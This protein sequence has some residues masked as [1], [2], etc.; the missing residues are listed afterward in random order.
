VANEAGSGGG[1]TPSKATL[2]LTGLTINAMALIAPGAFLWLTYAMQSQYGAPMA[3]SGM[4][5]GIVVALALCFATAIAYAELSKLYPGAGSSYFFAEQ[6]FLSKTKYA[7]FARVAKFVTGWASHL[8]YWVYP[9]VMVGVTALIAGYLLGQFWPTTF[10]PAVPSPL[11]MILFCVVF[12]FGVAYIAFRG[13]T[14]TTGVNMAINVIQITA[15]LIFSFMAISYRMKHPEGATAYT[16]DADNRVITFAVQNFKKDEKLG[17]V[18]FKVDEKGNALTFKIDEK[19]DFV[20][21][22]K[23]AFIAD[24]KG[25]AMPAADGETTGVA[26]VFDDNGAPLKDEKTGEYIAQKDKD[27]NDVPFRVSYAAAGSVTK[28][29][30]PIDPNK[31]DGEKQARFQYHAD[32]ASVFAPHS[33]S[34]AFIQACVAILI[35]VG[36]ESVTSMGEE[37]KNAKRDIPRAVLL[38]LGIQGI[39]C[40]LIQYFAANYFLNSGYTMTTAAASS[41]PIG[42]M[43]QIVGTWFF[44]TRAGGDWFM[45][46]QAFS[47][48][49][50]LI[51]TTLSCMAT[52][53]R[54]TYAM[55]RDEEV[56]AHFGMV[57]G[58]TLTPHRAIW[59]LATISAIIGIVCVAFNFCGPAAQSDEAIKL[60]PQNAWYSFGLFSNALATKLPQSLLMMTL[61]SNFGTFMLY[62]LTC[63]T[64]M[65]AFQEHHTF[66]GFKH[67]FIPVFGLMANLACMLF[68]LVG[69]FVVTGMS[70]MEPFLALG[71]AACWGIYGGIYFLSSSKKKGKPVVLDG[72]P[73]AVK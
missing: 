38:S 51:G 49:L 11:F 55:G 1:Q 64:A 20:K 24:E 40:Y 54:V 28:D 13:V 73:A 44:G 23:G 16:K 50:A 41:A 39:I 21:D 53:A 69:P 56:P 8:Y 43:M 22:E 14:G 66:N 59:T 57:H 6:A 45:L 7:K 35:L 36:F 9:G 26:Y 46:V 19:G 15:L 72:V 18:K 68:Y 3:G 2:G 37:A 58:K 30:D 52:G 33:I 34:Y 60:L 70:K 27:G 5:F 61:V 32:G 65:I 42:D 17:V 62:M 10:S 31:P 29:G 12:S 67:M 4:W 48:F 25:K 71:F 63:L 47:V